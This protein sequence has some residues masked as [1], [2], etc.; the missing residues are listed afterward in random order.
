MAYTI[1]NRFGE[2]VVFRP[3]SMQCMLLELLDPTKDNL[4]I[5]FRQTG[6]STMIKFIQDT[7]WP[8]LRCETVVG[9]PDTDWNGIEQRTAT[10]K[11]FNVI[12]LPFKYMKE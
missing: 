4:V 7:L 5:C 12:V 9:G 3:N 11:D 6:A 10:D 8:H 1:T 2:V